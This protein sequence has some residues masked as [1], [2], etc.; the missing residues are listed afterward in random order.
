MEYIISSS[1][2]Y[3]TVNGVDY[4]KNFWRINPKEDT[5]HIAIVSAPH[6]TTIKG[7]YSEFLNGD[8]GNAP[9]ASL[10][11]LVSHFR[12]IV[13]KAG[14][15]G[16]EGATTDASALTSGTLNPNR[17]GNNSITEEKLSE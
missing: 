9:F 1:A 16:G 6:N 3:F 2:N 10:N 12:D 7:H 8:N 13:F 5:G 4:P 17:I 15:G 14:G 11:A